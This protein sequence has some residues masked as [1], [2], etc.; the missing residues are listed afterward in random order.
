MGCVAVYSSD[1]PRVPHISRFL[2]DVGIY[3]RIEIA[4]F[5]VLLYLA[6][7][8]E[9]AVS[10]QAEAYSQCTNFA[11]FGFCA[12]PSDQF[13]ISMKRFGMTPM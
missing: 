5:D 4:S 12:I 10:T 3:G 7:T 13:T 8:A 6:Q 9:A 2:R 11:T 1:C